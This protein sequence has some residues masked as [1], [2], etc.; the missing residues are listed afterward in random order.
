[1][2][3]KSQK[4]SLAAAVNRNEYPLT[5]SGYRYADDVLNGIIETGE[6]VRLAAERFARDLQNDRLPFVFDLERSEDFL[7]FAERMPHTKGRWAARREN[8]KLEPWQCFSFANLFGWVDEKGHRRFREAYISVPRKNGKSIIGAVVGNYMFAAD[9]EYGAEVYSGATSEKQAWEVYRPAQIMCKKTPA[10]CEAYDIDINAKTMVVASDGS[11]FEPVIGDPGDGASPSCAI[12]DEYHEHKDSRLFDTMD[13]GMG[14]RD[15]PLLL[16]ITTAGHSLD[17]P[18][19]DKQEEV[20]AILTGNVDNDRL[21]GIVYAI[22][23]GDDFSDPKVL[24]KANPNLG[25]SVSEGFLLA[26]QKAAVDS[27][28]KQNAFRTKHLNEWVDA[29]EAYFNTTNWLNCVDKDLDISAFDGQECAI[30]LDLAQKSDFAAKVLTF[31]D[32]VDGKLVYTL[33]PKLYLP[34]D[35]IPE[36]KTGKYRR[37]RDA[38]HIVATEGNEIDFTVIQEDILADMKRFGLT[39]CNYDP[40]YAT[41]LSQILRAEGVPMIEYQQTAAKMGP[42][43]DELLTAMD[44]GRLRHDGNP[45]MAW[46]I[47]NVINYRPKAKLPAPAKQNKSNKI[48]GAVAA[49]MA[50]AHLMDQNENFDAFGAIG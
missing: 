43:M 13:T 19:Y 28:S 23:K 7:E 30:G 37:W 6:L 22:D 50:I 48:D 18:C 25:V 33:F 5:W 47:G 36:D 41:Q 38:G 16:V 32:W 44:S 24:R 26:K 21:F 9:R 27:A 31:A 49:M 29:K 17:G 39:G 15:Q 4:H 46:M 2:A 8:I 35:R 45:C 11:R 42:P 3:R 34:E 20:K 1:M 40:A 12:V 14:S 10:F